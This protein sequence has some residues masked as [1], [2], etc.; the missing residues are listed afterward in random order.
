[1]VLAAPAADGLEVGYRRRGAL[2]VAPD[3]D[4]AA[5]LRRLHGDNGWWT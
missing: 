5:Q 4:G 2:Q 1:M 3:R